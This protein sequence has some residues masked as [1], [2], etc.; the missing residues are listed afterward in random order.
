[1]LLRGT[2]Q[3]FADDLRHFA[4]FDTQAEVG[5]LIGTPSVEAIAALTALCRKDAVLLAQTQ[6][7]E[8]LSPA[9]SLW[10]AEAATLFTLPSEEALPDSGDVRLLDLPHLEELEIEDELKEEFRQALVFAPLAAGYHENQP[11]SFCY[12]VWQTETLWD[13]SIDTLPE[14]QEQGH[15]ARTVS[16]MIRFMAGAGKRP[17]WGALESNVASSRLAR[18]LGFVPAD[19]IVVFSQE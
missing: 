6:N 1:M 5:V 17:V 12:P 14:F 10:R 11:V 8:E 16:W 13:I 4:L 3:I 7:A 2:A 9:L 18:K 19:Q 15:A